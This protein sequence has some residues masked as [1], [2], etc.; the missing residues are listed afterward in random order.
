MKKRNL[1]LALSLMLFILLCVSLLAI[2]EEKVTLTFLG[3][4]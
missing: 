4:I 1:S 3:C 2:A